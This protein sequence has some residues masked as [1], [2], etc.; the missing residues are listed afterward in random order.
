MYSARRQA[1][2][3][4]VRR[5]FYGCACAL[6]PACQLALLVTAF[7]EHRVEACAHRELAIAAFGCSMVAA[8]LAA[9]G[10]ALENA[11]MLLACALSTTIPLVRSW[12]AGTA[13][14]ANAAEQ[15]L[16]ASAAALEIAVCALALALW[17]GFGWR[18]Y[19]VVGGDVALNAVYAAYQA[20]EAVTFLAA[21]GVLLL[22]SAAHA[23][24]ALPLAAAVAMCAIACGSVPAQLLAMR[25]ERGLALVLALSVHLLVIVVSVGALASAPREARAPAWLCGSA[26]LPA[27]GQGEMRTP[28][29]AACVIATAALALLVVSAARVSAHFGSGLRARAFAQHGGADGDGGEGGRTGGR[30]G[31]TWRGARVRFVI[32]PPGPLANFAAAEP[33]LE[34]ILEAHSGGLAGGGAAAGVLGSER[35][36]REAEVVGDEWAGGGSGGSDLPVERGAATSSLEPLIAPPAAPQPRSAEAPAAA[37]AAN[38]NADAGARLSAP[39][40][41]CAG[42][43]QDEPTPT[44]PATPTAQ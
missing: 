36:E 26:R 24:G 14:D 32:P 43:G 41:E 31:F 25:A 16:F 27:D 2:P 40:S 37:G 38:G 22:A 34:P 11:H 6:F 8:L 39:G 28:A 10:S 18:A 3:S 15:A 33:S 4:A 42:G 5:A 13:A 30:T 44:S 17:R 35:E 29:L 7:A 20:F 12:R 21:E 19:S 1:R 23:V 9:L